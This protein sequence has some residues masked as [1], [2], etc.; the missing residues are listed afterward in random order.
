VTFTTAPRSASQNSV[1]SASQ[2]GRRAGKVGLGAPGSLVGIPTGYPKRGAS[3]ALPI[4]F[5]C[6]GIVLAATGGEFFVRGL[7]GLASWAR[8]PARVIGA[9]I[10]AFATSS[11]ELTVAITA[12]SEGRPE[13]ALGDALGSNVVNIGL[14]V[15][16]VLLMGM[17]SPSQVSRTDAVTAIGMALL[18]LVMLLNGE[19]SRLDGAVLL[20]VFAFWLVNTT[21]EAVSSRDQ[22]VEALGEKRHGRSIAEAFVGLV[23]LVAA[24]RFLVVGAK[25]IGAELGISTFVVGVVLVS[26]GT[27]LPELATAVISRL[28][29]YADLG[30]GTA[31]GSNIFNTSFIVGVAAM[32]TP[33]E[34]AVREAAFSLLVG[35]AMIPVLLVGTRGAPLAR[36]RG[37]ILIVG[38]VLS[39]VVLLG[40]E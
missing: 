9:T 13:I 3:V 31:L 21:K 23:C 18:L 32:I 15:G 30:I 14:V 12:A 19:L 1:E 34:V 11:P 5:L 39:I 22:V 2:G 10:A 33:I 20:S 7:V 40:T 8:V 36:W 24:G 26:F 25:E 37:A 29:G 17:T 4:L 28:R 27:S 16:I 38:Y 6:V 35:V